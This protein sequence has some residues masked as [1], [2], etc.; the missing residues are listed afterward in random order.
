[1]LKPE[2]HPEKPEDYAAVYEVNR[3]AFGR[4]VEGRLVEALRQS[5]DHFPELSLVAVVAGRV[6]GH[7]LFS[8]IAIEVPG[9]RIP[10]L[11]LAPLAVRPEFQK[12]GIGS[13][14]VRYG[15]EQCR[16][17]GHKIVVVIGHPDYYPR[18]GF[19]SARAEGL[20]VPFPVP[21]E[22]FMA[23]ELVP[24]ALSGISGMVRYSPAF[25][26]VS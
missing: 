7:I 21:D 13:E 10:A 14:L 9:T 15:L 17:L 2:I 6:V 11:G 3:L 18:F 20:E 12:K 23:L 22:A 24:G 25:D 1:L 4:E 8:A 26:E 5:P 16:R 19:S